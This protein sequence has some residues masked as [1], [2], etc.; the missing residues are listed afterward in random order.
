[1]ATTAPAPTTTTL[2]SA[3][4]P[5]EACC[6]G[7][8]RDLPPTTTTMEQTRAELLVAQARI[9]ELEAQVRQLNQKATA[10][11]DR[12][13]EYEAELAKLRSTQAA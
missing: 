13:A 9:Q 8:G 3:P 7:C 6:P 11:V 10:A 5:G 12:W 1:M 4:A 2:R